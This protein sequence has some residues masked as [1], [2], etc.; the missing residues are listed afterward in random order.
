LLR[1]TGNAVIALVAVTANEVVGHIVFSPV[2]VARAPETFRAVGLGPVA[3]LPEFQANGIG[4]K[5]IRDGLA[6]CRDNGYDAVVLLGDPDYYTR[7][8]FSKASRRH[9]K[10]EYGVDAEFMV[11]ELRPGGLDGVRGLVQYG[12]EF[13]EAGA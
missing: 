8:G 11:L 10:N 9:L 12:P 4:S 6:I 7:F 13:A 3:V 2:S 1:D 5:L